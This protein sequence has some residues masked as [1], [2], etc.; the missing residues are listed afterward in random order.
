MQSRRPVYRLPWKCKLVDNG[1][2]SGD[3]K[4]WTALRIL[5]I[6]KLLKIMREIKEG[7]DTE[8]KAGQGLKLET[9][10]LKG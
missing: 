10:T 2:S 8:E 9:L 7:I 5:G 1:G 4:Q 6:G 3:G